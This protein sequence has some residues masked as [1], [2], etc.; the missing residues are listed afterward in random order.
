MA[1]C[2]LQADTLLDQIWES[3]K[4]RDVA[5]YVR[6][7]VEKLDR[8]EPRFGD[9]IVI[10]GITGDGTVPNYKISPINKPIDLV[11]PPLIKPEKEFSSEERYAHEYLV[12]SVRGF[13]G[14]SHKPLTNAS[15]EANWSIK[16]LKGSDV[17]LLLGRIRASNRK[18]HDILSR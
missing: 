11:M 5:E 10:I 18:S 6:K 16:A 12:M 4:L 15:G 13:N 9:C 2:K 17:R 7:I 1:H 14:R 8:Y 3:G